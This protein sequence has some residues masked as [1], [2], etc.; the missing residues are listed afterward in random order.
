[1]LK[2]FCLAAA[3]MTV[4][5]APA[6]AAGECGSAPI[7]P[8][9]PAASDLAGKTVEAG[10][11]EVVDA[12]HQVKAY[13]ASLQPFRGCLEQQAKVDQT[14]LAAAQADG[15]KGKDKVA[16]LQQSM[17]DMQKVYDH[18]VDTETQVATDFNNLHVAQCKVDTDPK[19]CPKKQ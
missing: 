12:Y 6:F 17:A 10:R 14:A 16:T 11:A 1:M 2:S 7:A 5:A 13:Q 4:V 18:T 3:M 9:I 19:I 8:A 15:E